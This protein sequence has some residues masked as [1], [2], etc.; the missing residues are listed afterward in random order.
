[1][2][3]G[4]PTLKEGKYD[5]KAIVAS[6]R[7]YLLSH[8]VSL[9][10]ALITC[11]DSDVEVQYLVKAKKVKTKGGKLGECEPTEAEDDIESKMEA[12]WNQ[13]QQKALEAALIKY[14]KG[15]TQDRWEKIAKCVPGKTKVRSINNKMEFAF[16]YHNI[17]F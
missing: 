9:P 15:S 10:M 3:T 16:C 7:R 4:L 6:G 5:F 8:E 1:M 17:L 14:P 13:V 12:S 2:V 11:R